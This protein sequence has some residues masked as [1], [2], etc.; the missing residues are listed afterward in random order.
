VPRASKISH[1]RSR[2]QYILT[3]NLTNAVII[4]QNQVSQDGSRNRDVEL[5][6]MTSHVVSDRLLFTVTENS[7]IWNRLVA[8]GMP[9][10][11]LTELDLPTVNGFQWV[12]GIRE[13]GMFEAL[14]DGFVDFRV[15][16]VLLVRGPS[17]RDEG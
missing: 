4:A 17:I 3:G 6:K 14:K 7:S 16:V 12:E 2:H 10:W 8:I 13:L 1:Q 11:I 5:E 15:E 9:E